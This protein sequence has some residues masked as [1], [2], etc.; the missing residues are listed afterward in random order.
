[1]ARKKR[2]PPG[3][4]PKPSPRRGPKPRARAQAEPPVELRDRRAME[5]VMR[6]YLG[7]LLGP[8][9]ETPLS[10]AQDIIYRAFD[11]RDAGKRVALARQ[12]LALSADCADA[13]VLLAE[14]ARTRKERLDLYQQAVAAGERAL[15]PEGFRE[16]AGH[17][18]G[19][20]E[21]RPY[22]RAREGL[23]STL[24]TLG[25]REEAAEH[26]R[27]M[28]RLNPGDN[29]GV[30]YILSSWLLNLDRDDE[31]ARLLEGYDEILANFAYTRALLAF[32][33]RG[34]SAEPRD[35][36]KAARKANRHVPKFLL[37]EKRL[38]AEQPSYH[39][40]GDENEAI[41]YAGS[42]LSAWR[43]TPGALAWLMETVR[44]KGTSSPKDEG[45]PAVGPS[46]LAKV[47][48]KRLPQPFDIWQAE[49]R[50]MASLVMHEGQLVQPW[51]TLVASDTSGLVL[52]QAMTIETPSAARIWDVLAQAMG[53]PPIDHPHRPAQV[54]VRPDSTWDEL[55][56]HLDEIG[57]D[58]VE[59]HE[60]ELIDFLFD[61]LTKHLAGQG[62]PGLLEMPG[63][64]P[65]RVS[66]FYRA[67]AEF[68]RR[69]PWRS[70]GYEEAIRI[71]TDRYE[72]GPWYAVVMGQSGMTLG[73]ALY[74]DLGLLRHLWSQDL[75]DEENARQSVSL[76]VTF[77]PPNQ[78]PTAD[79]LAGREHG[80]EVAGP[81]AYP[82]V[83]KKELGMS[84]RP[85]LAW[86]LELLEGCLRAIPDFI[87][88]QRPGDTTP[89][90]MTVP[91]ASGDLSLVLSWVEEA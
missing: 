80:W 76:T 4:G 35:L 37:G 57:V 56:P 50:P 5:G 40:L 64:T 66:R 75:P 68:Y 17:F 14:Q 23:A 73:V 51:M 22:M 31:L 18:W 34:D 71:A 90:R 39:G 46:A 77:D 26:L 69:A 20:L 52:A 60:L 78:I 29:Q 36:L 44:G 3:R 81:E 27:E 70:L 28:L 10:Q 54:Q 48:L 2:Q 89:H 49:R 83:F 41:V 13:L 15:G 24:W 65:E 1:M 61:D 58:C 91:V 72:S 7:E 25:R 30:R 74:E 32:R 43:S 8:V 63:L 38:P 11:E 33:Q 85:P 19:V 84:L 87:A 82:C 55:R 62:P 47:R 88:A 45:P 9:E 16:N 79:L 59:A 6:G 67:A 86:E 21:T 53:H 42:A 12:A